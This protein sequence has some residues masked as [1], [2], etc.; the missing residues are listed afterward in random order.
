MRLGVEDREVV[1]AVGSSGGAEGESIAA[2]EW[3]R[4]G[5]GIV[6]VR[7]LLRPGTAG[8]MG[9]RVD[10]WAYS[11]EVAGDTLAHQVIETLGMERCRL[12]RAGGG[13]L[14]GE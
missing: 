8:E 1:T 9:R 6:A 13:L 4:G 11:F 12:G 14:P 10:V 5:E 3:E 7:V 2:R